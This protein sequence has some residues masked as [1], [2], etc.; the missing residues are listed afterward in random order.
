MLPTGI[1]RGGPSRKKQWHRFDNYKQTQEP[2]GSK[3]TAKER[4]LDIPSA[5]FEGPSD[6]FGHYALV[7]IMTQSNHHA[8]WARPLRVYLRKNDT[9][10]SVVGIERD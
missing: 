6:G 5:A 3:I 9:G 8:G 1:D 7:D 4:R 2:F 10:V